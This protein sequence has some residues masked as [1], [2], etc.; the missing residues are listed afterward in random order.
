MLIAVD[1]GF[2]LPHSCISLVEVP[3]SLILLRT[4]LNKSAK[5]ALSRHVG[6]PCTVVFYKYKQ[7][8]F[9]TTVH[10]SQAT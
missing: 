7:L 4:V 2:I 3:I 9:Q 8:H 6:S 5:V 1:L 10:Y